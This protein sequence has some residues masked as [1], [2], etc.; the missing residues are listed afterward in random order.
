MRT[1]RQVAHP[2]V[3]RVYDIGE[4]G[5]GGRHFIS[6]EYVD[7][8]DLAS[9]LRRIGGL[10]QPKA[11]EIAR[12]LC[13]G[14]SAAH[15]RGV[16]H[17]DLKPANIMVDGRGRSRIMDFGLAVA[18]GDG[19][20][21]TE[22]AGTPAYMAPE[23]F[24]GAGA[25]LR[26]DLYALGL[27][28]FELYTG[29][30]AFDAPTLAGYRQKHAE[31]TPS[32]PSALVPGLDPAV[33]RAILRCVEK[34]PKMRPSSAA[35][36][37]AAL[38]GGDPLAA[39]LAAGETPSP[40]MVAAAGSEDRLSPAVARG[41]VVAAV[42]IMLLHAFLAPRVCLLP[43]AGSEKSG[44]VLRVRARELL[45]SLGMRD[46][47]AD[48][49]GTLVNE[50]GFFVWA[51]EHDR[52]RDR[53]RR[54]MS[55]DGLSYVYRESPLPL[56]P[57]FLTLGPFPQ[58]VVT[59]LDPSPL[60]TGMKEVRLDPEG[61]L[62]ELHVVPEQV[63]RPSAPA[64]AASAPDWTP[65]FRAAGLDANSFRPVEPRWNP[66]SYADARAA[67]EGPHP[68]RP[69]LTMRVEAAAHRARPIS[70]L[71]IGPWSTSSRDVPDQRDA[72]ARVGDLVWSLI[73]LT[74]M[75]AGAWMA[76]RNLRAGRGDRRG[77]ARLAAAVV[78]MQFAMWALGAHH[79]S[80]VDELDV[81][82]GGLAGA[83]VIGAVAWIV[84][85]ALEPIMRRLWPGM[86]ISWTRL[87]AGGWKDP[88][89]GRDLV[90]GA[91]AGA[92]IGI[93]MGPIRRYIP[94]WLGELPPIPRGLLSDPSSV[95]NGVAWLINSPAYAIW[96]VLALVMFLVFIRRLVR[97][98]WL[99][100][101]IVAV[102]FS[103]NY[104]GAPLPAVTLPMAAA[105]TGL[106]VVIAI[107]FGLLAA[108]VCRTCEY[109]LEYW[110]MTPDPSAWY[111]YVGAI[112]MGMVLALALWGLHTTTASGGGAVT[113]EER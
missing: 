56:V 32:S 110:V 14:L 34:D 31:E 36:V 2:N 95:R 82:G 22:V 86:L 7:G 59:E 63:E 28:L 4:T 71:W 42:A 25:S 98:E 58:P 72:A 85:V 68:E 89:V 80:T 57:G 102:F 87:V 62:K 61:R 91:S 88:L 17:R 11:L 78:L 104:L 19:T 10:T 40:E 6:M 74:L 39:A 113:V 41:L 18:E 83:A 112:A 97:F 21:G 5:E 111:F 100:A 3:C 108:L 93:L 23:L 107:R 44:E 54:G 49:A 84:Y 9:L 55:R 48:R 53:W 103:A 106:L 35:Q 60:R 1:A 15:E 65:L 52:S 24:S 47:P 51:N 94:I 75:F 46:R 92:L 27:V 43:L 90:V 45:A 64:A 79:V 33:E 81:L 26:S 8:E 67:W 38:P 37:A 99:A 101:I 13:A 16:L 69:G 66:R 109:W 70:F 105:T 73:L 12:Q 50:Y 76:R 29:K 20:G 30:H 96:W 77:A